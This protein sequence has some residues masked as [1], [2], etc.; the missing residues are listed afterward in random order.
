MSVMSIINI[1]WNILLFIFVV[2][3]SGPDDVETVED[4][5]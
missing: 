2:L 4:A 3:N 1:L 5:D